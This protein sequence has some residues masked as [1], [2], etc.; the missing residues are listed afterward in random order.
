MKI[1]KEGIIPPPKEKKKTCK[2]CNCEFTYTE[3]D[4]KSDYW[5][6]GAIKWVECP[7]CNTTVI[8]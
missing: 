6:D 3:V 1:I 2:K 8:V 5:D 7:T 4:I